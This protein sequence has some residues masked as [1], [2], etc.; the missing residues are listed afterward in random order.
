VQERVV[1]EIRLLR[2]IVAGVGDG[3]FRGQIA[4]LVDLE[5][6]CC[7][8]LTFQIVVE[9]QSGPLRLLVTGPAGAKAVIADFFG[10][11]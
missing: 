7:P 2:A 3:I 6:Q 8:F 11:V 5:R 1:R 10:G 4:L 9:A